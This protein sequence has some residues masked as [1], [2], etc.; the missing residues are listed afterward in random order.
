MSARVS[1]F[2]LAVAATILCTFAAA[3]SLKIQTEENQAV[4]ECEAIQKTWIDTPRVIIFGE[5]HGTDEAP[6][7]IAELACNIAKIA[8]VVIGIEYPPSEQPTLDMFMKAKSKRGENDAIFSSSF[9]TRDF[10]DGKTSSAMLRMLT[11]IKQL[12][13]GGAKI[14]ILAVG[15][16]GPGQSEA[17]LRNIIT[18]ERNGNS[19][20]VALVGNGHA[21]KI[22]LQSTKALGSDIANLHRRTIEIKYSSGTAWACAPTC[23]IQH[24][25]A[26][27][28]DEKEISLE[29]VA[30]PENAAEHLG[31]IYLGRSHASPPAVPEGTTSEFQTNE[32]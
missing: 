27:K 19:R 1:A 29:E 21:R 16:E 13:N 28:A 10:Q 2:Q 15:G 5:V 24:F 30:P 32:L 18:S 23:R 31:E 3:S 7:F 9:W 25:G 8:P 20:I 12:K 14:D 6:R 11:R 4:Q 22:H 17:I 26:H